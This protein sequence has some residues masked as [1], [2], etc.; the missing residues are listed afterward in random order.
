MLFLIGILLIALIVLACVVCRGLAPAPAGHGP[1]ARKSP[2]R[3]FRVMAGYAVLA[4]ALIILLFRP[5]EEIEIGED[6]AAYFNAALSYAGQQRLRFP[7]PAFSQ[8]LPAERKLFRYGHRGFAITKDN[9]LWSRDEQMAD[10]GPHFLPAYS[11][12]LS[13]PVFLGFP[14]AAF[15]TSPVFAVMIAWLLA[16]LA[17]WLTGERLAG[18][19]TFGLFIL[20]PAVIWNARC[21]RAE[22]PASFLILAGVVI[23]LAPEATGKR[24][25]PF[26]AFLGGLAL[27]AAGWFHG[28]AFFVLIPAVLISLWLTR[29]SAFWKAWWSGLIFGCGLFLAQVIWLTDPYQLGA[30]WGVPGRRNA[31]LLSAI[32]VVAV[33]VGL[34]RFWNRPARLR[35]PARLRREG[36]TGGLI[37]LGFILIV[38]LSLRYR[39]DQ[40]LMTGLPAWPVTYLSLT[41]FR[42]VRQIFSRT[43]FW[44]ALAGMVVICV[45]SGTPG[46]I[47]RRIFLLLAPGSLMIGWVVN[48][49]FETRRMVTFLVPLFVLSTTVIVMAAGSW[50]AGGF[51]RR[52]PVLS[53]MIEI[54]L[55]CLLTG[56]VITNAVLGRTRI[57][58][59]WNNRGTYRFYR[60]L[61]GE[62]REAG[63]FLFAEYTQTAVP[64]ERLSGLPLLPISWGYRSE[65]EYRKAEEVMA[66]LVRE[67]PGR[68]H[69]MISPFSGAAVPGVQVEPLFSRTLETARLA[70]ARLSVPGR[71]IPIRRTLHLH[72]LRP[73]GET[74]NSLPY[75]RV[76]DRG[77]LGLSGGANFIPGRSIA[78]RGV[79]LSGESAGNL[80]VQLPRGRGQGRLL[81]AIAFPGA[82]PAESLAVD[83]FP[84]PLA[85]PRQFNLGPGWEAVELELGSGEEPGV[86]LDIR[87]SRPAYLT[88]VFWVEDSGEDIRRVEPSSV[89]TGFLMEE[90]SFQ[91]IR[92]E[93][94]VALPTATVPLR[95]W[96]LAASGREVPADVRVSVTPRAGDVEGFSFPVSAEWNWHLVPIPPSPEEGFD[97]FDLEV[98]PAWD[99]GLPGYPADLGIILRLLTV[100]PRDM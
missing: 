33:L 60:G 23:W 29:R 18:W 93:A 7:D 21:L 92:A 16:L 78:F 91:W 17:V 73:P 20:N 12:I 59:T 45:R 49:M 66:R 3:N 83:S 74:G 69:L 80:E 5:D 58:T 30:L 64:V 26:A 77:R 51:R 65:A 96:M 90:V 4:V 2:W 72:R 95:L 89:K 61:A 57:Y 46:R 99:P 67:R 70:R 87:S 27:A 98:D 94:A 37:S 68:R 42:G 86:T 84:A 8:I 75:T 11:I 34:R 15:W 40:G 38:L 47:G 31:L 6:A 14:Y 50:V 63:D 97:W 56:L 35:T 9:S 41:D 85:G 43:G 100:V 32:L 62:A 48:Y 39:D 36:L 54:G 88:D 10:V 28:T 19:L 52:R 53:R 24:I 22:W 81:C 44:L 71:I 13:V 82:G 76:M 79:R 1:G 55:P 25:S